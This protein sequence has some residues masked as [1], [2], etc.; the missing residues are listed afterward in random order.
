MHDRFTTLLISFL[1]AGCTTLPS[2]TLQSLDDE[3]IE[4]NQVVTENYVKGNYKTAL[5]L[6][7]ELLA[8]AEKNPDPDRYNISS[9]YNNLSMIHLKLANYHASKS[10]LKKALKIRINEYG[11]FHPIVAVTINNLGGILQEEKNYK[12]SEFYFRKAL[13]LKERTGDNFSLSYTKTLSNIGLSLMYQGKY[14][15]AE[16]YLLKTLNLNKKIAGQNH[17]AV[18]TDYT[19]IASLKRRQGKLKGIEALYQRAYRI[20]LNHFGEDHPNT[21]LVFR[22]TY[23]YYIQIGRK[24]DAIELTTSLLRQADLIDLE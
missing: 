20:F 10:T 23:S 21:N 24:E 15:D 22:N 8:Y 13:K 19:N 12:E 9:S 11:D 4:Q 7:T 5:V 1:F 14:D 3:W 18:A 2:T 16:I 6:A 17:P